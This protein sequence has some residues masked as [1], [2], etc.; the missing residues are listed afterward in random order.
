[1][2]EGTRNYA[3]VTA[4]YWG[5]TL[6]DGALRMLVL[7]HFFRLGYSPFTLAF[8]FLL[9]EAAGIVANLIGG[10][11]AAR[12]GITRMLAIGLTTQI[13]GFLL[14]SG[15]SPDWTA[16]ASVAWVVMAQGICGVAKDLTKTASKSAI[17]VAE[18]AAMTQD[19]QGRLFRWVAWF[20]GSK[21]AMKGVGFFLGGFLLEALGFR[22]AL[23]AMA[24]MLAL[25]LLGVLTSLPAMMGK[26][27]ASRSA[28]ELFAKN[29]GVNLLALARV[30]L[31]GARD[32]WFVVGVPVFL[33]GSGWTFTMVGT[34]LALWTVGY[35]LVQAAA[36][37]FVRR[38]PDGLSSEVPA[39]RLWSLG[40]AAV[41]FA[42]AGL[43]AGGAGLRPDMVLVAGLGLF[44][45]AFAVNSSVHSYLILAYAGSE[46]SAEDVGFYYAAN[47]LGRFLG[48]L[49]S[50]LLYQAGGIQACLIGSGLMLAACFVA[51]MALP[52]RP[53]SVPARG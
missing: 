42:I 14:L 22:G 29:R 30:A 32:V 26:A 49:M 44:G 10:W 1:V 27:K 9:Y 40:L 8:L 50:G 17:K 3:I 18:A 5:F 38:S 34:F 35:G 43:L 13:I 20:T 24:A 7:L 37:A 16:A 28:R 39:A 23:W 12:Y 51:T 46:K 41:P 48:T 25:I 4:A 19:S 11:L 21:N 6:T 15:L 36:P 31:F 52:V 47:A 2:T 33:Y 53:T 45:F